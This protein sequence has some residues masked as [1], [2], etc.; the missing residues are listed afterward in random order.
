MQRTL[1]HRRR[2]WQIGAMNVEPTTWAM[3]V[4]ILFFVVGFVGSLLPFIPGTIMVFLGIL[5]H[6]LWVP[7][8]S[9]SW[10][11]VALAGGVVAV[12]QLFDYLFGVW[13]ARRFGASKAGAIGAVVGGIIGL[14]IPPQPFWLIFGPGAGAIAGE[15]M[16]G[17]DLPGAGRAGV[18]TLVGG[19]VAF[20]IKLGITCLLIA[21][22]YLAL[23]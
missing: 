1:A 2:V 22:F 4:A 19:V 3:A 20:V 7:T 17:R 15:L 21:G 13:G 10:T 9:V 18:G 23:P 12:A 6:K 8:T 11:F 16:T 5:I 14:F